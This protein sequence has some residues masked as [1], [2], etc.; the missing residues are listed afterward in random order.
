MHTDLAWRLSAGFLLL[1]L[2]FLAAASSCNGFYLPW[3]LRDG[4]WGYSLPAMVD[5]TAAR[6]FVYRQ[7]LPII[8]NAVYLGLPEPVE[9][10]LVRLLPPIAWRYRPPPTCV[11]APLGFALLLLVP[12][13]ASTIGRHSRGSSA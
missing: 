1:C 6:P 5:G 4:Q 8:A 13:I 3:G 11:L 9:I 2:Y 7:L 10:G 12:L